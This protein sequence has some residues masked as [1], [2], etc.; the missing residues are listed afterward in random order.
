MI[1]AIRE[2]FNTPDPGEDSLPHHLPFQ[3][4]KL[5]ED[6]N[7]FAALPYHALW[8]AGWDVEPLSEDDPFRTLVSLQMVLFEKS[9]VRHRQITDQCVEE[10]TGMAVDF[11]RRVMASRGVGEDCARSPLQ[12]IDAAAQK[13]RARG[14]IALLEASA[15]QIEA[16]VEIAQPA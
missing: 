8:D 1:L 4:W 13:L 3:S 12:R 9:I 15:T 7:T 2:Y 6:F 16:L 14:Q 5:V 11:I 10:A